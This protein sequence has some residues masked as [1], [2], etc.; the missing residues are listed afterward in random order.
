MPTPPNK[1]YLYLVKI[2]SG[3][4]YSEHKLREKLIAKKYSAEEI[5]SA[6]SEIKIRG[7]LRE[8]IFAEARVKGFM[9][10]GYSP[11]Y[12]RQRLAQEHLTVTDEEIE[13]VFTEHELTTE[14][15]I[16]RLVRKKIQGKTE[17]D[18]A[19]ESKIL[20]YLLSKGHDFGDSKKV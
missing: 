13:A 6:I 19:G 17:F 14:N 18:Y 8:E 5:E 4:D 12:I 11:D 3:R 1:A 20:R 15:Q 10:R 9:E 2:I 16:D 7:F